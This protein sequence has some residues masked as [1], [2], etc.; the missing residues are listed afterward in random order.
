MA[1]AARGG[2]AAR[3]CCFVYGSLLAPEVLRSLLGRVP[4]HRPARLAGHERHALAGRPYP[5]VVP[6]ARAGAAVRGLLLEGLSAEEEAIFDEFE[7][8]EYV[9]RVVRVAPEAEASSS[10]PPEVEAP[11]YIYKDSPAALLGPW[12]YDQVSGGRPT[13]GGEPRRLVAQRGKGGR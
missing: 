7:G 6:S 5:G 11:V 10:P 13:R 2:A 8:D 4:A 9:K 1:A 12:S 3:A